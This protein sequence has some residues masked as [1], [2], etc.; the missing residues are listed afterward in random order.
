MMRLDSFVSD[1]RSKNTFVLGFF[2]RELTTPGQ[3]QTFIVPKSARLGFY[4]LH[5]LRP[6]I[7]IPAVTS[8]KRYCGSDDA[9]L[10]IKQEQR[11]SLPSLERAAF[12]LLRILK[13][14]SIGRKRE[15]FWIS[16]QTVIPSYESTTNSSQQTHNSFSRRLFL[17]T[18]LSFFISCFSV[19]PLRFSDTLM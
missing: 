7:P 15:Y 9:S 16:C 8:T 4:L 10:W 13:G 5:F 6:A 11:T 14:Q 12:A 18:F 19:T 17:N 3:I 2:S 1:A